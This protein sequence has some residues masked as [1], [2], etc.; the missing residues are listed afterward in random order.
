M[1]NTKKKN[2][3]NYLLFRKCIVDKP[4]PEFNR[5][6][7]GMLH[8]EINYFIFF[9]VLD[10]INLILDESITLSTRTYLV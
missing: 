8:C 5:L 4:K 6:G 3:M 1:K 9:F 10:V 7:C 2:G